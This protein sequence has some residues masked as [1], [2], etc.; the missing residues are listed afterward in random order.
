MGKRRSRLV[1]WPRE[2]L[3]RAF[4]LIE[5]L[6]V[7]SIIAILAGLVLASL[8]R[9]RD[10]AR[11]IQCLNNL[12]QMGIGLT[13][14][15]SDNGRLPTF[16]EWLYPAPLKGVTVPGALDLTKG[17]LY[18][19]LRS[20]DIYRCPSEKGTHPQFGP[21]DHSYQMPCMIC[22]AHDTSA[23]IAPSRTVH[24][25]EVVNQARS[26]GTGMATVPNPPQLAFRHNQREHFL[27]V[28]GHTERLT[29]RQYTNAV[30]DKRFWYPTTETG[31][32]GYP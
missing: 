15:A 23:C 25:L 1:A 4:T 13:V 16:L 22:H 31:T 18:P 27:F 19:Y 26:F 8:T 24:M 29:A 30:S 32:K 21:I 6:V 28:D 7:I 5:L 2:T 11:G 20:Q 17:Q 3:Q 9:G 12:R 10:A 14:Y